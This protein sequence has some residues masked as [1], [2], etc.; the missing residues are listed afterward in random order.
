MEPELYSNEEARL[1]HVKSY[2]ILDTLPESDYDNLTAIAAE[3][4]DTPISLVSILDDKRQWFKSHH[5][6]E[7]KETPKKYAFCA[8]AILDPNDI[9][10]VPDAR[11][12]KRFQDNPL[13]TGDPYVIFYAG[14][15]LQGENG[16]PL[17][18]LCVI[19]NKPKQLNEQ[20]ITAL[21]ALSRQTMNLLEL[22][23]KSLELEATLKKLEDRN[24]D[25]EKFA[26]IAAHDIKSP[27]NN[28]SEIV[29]ILIK[30]HRSE[31]N[32]E[33]I[34]L[35]NFV[36]GAADNLR[37]LVEGLL[38][39]SR[40][41]NTLRENV[42]EINLKAFIR[43]VIN[44]LN[45]RET[46]HLKLNIELEKIVINKTAL[47]QILINLLNNSIKYNDKEITKIEI[48]A[49]DHDGQYQF[50]IKDNGPG[51]PPAFQEHIF[52]IFKVFTL[53]DKYGK[54][55]NGIGLAT[56]K[57]MVQSMDGKVWVESQPHH[58]AQ[59]NFTIPKSR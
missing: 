25:L 32:P 10:V 41:E 7:V 18:T 23:K 3:I 46:C 52:E 51:I 34:Q 45:V 27:L 28:I 50:Y 17:G 2:S 22:R 58:G 43:E 47:E 39:Y 33:A 14:V 13:V 57:K 31:M 11:N 48:G 26:F 21:K 19:D 35:L 4:C 5:G 20:Q 40:S 30:N 15:P 54:P 53:K 9:M 16:L 24:Q 37:N 44:L 6:I 36:D 55:G 42:S 56:V 8:H 1:R 59:F 38:Q 12:D 49:L 29:D